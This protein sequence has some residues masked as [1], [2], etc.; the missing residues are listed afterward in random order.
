MK[1]ITKLLLAI[2]AV[3]AIGMSVNVDA[4]RGRHGGG[5]HHSG[6]HYSRSYYYGG[7]WGWGWGSPFYGRYYNTPV[8]ERTY[9]VQSSATQSDI[10][11][12]LNI[13]TDE[14]KKL[15]DIVREQNIKIMELE[16]HVLPG[17]P[18]FAR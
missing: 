16:K 4:R 10:I 1:K 8:V 7:G 5:R 14:I 15:Q 12:V 11:K 18:A 17:R 9:V 6:R 2:L 13:H 3:M